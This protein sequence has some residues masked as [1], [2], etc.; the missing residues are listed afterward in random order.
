MIARADR[1]YGLGRLQGAK[2]EKVMPCLA[3]R[4]AIRAARTEASKRPPQVGGLCKVTMQYFFAPALLAITE[5]STVALLSP[6]HT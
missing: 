1:G 5:R 6:Q 2:T 3:L 4:R